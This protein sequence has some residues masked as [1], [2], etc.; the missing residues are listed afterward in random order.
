M[1][2]IKQGVT[3]VI[4]SGLG[5]KAMAAFEESGITV[6]C[7]AAP[8]APYDL[9]RAYLNGTLATGENVCDH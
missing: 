1:K 6:L 3:V 9:V 4:A 7:G 8:E 5:R 2:K